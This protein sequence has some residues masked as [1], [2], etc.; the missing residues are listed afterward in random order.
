MK[1][2]RL[3]IAVAGATFALAACTNTAEPAAQP[4][5][6]VVGP[7]GEISLPEGFDRWPT[8][9][10][11]ATAAGGE[12]QPVDEM[13]TVY[14]SPGGIESY[15]VTGEF[16][17][18]T[19]LVKDV[20]EAK[21]TLLTTGDAHWPTDTKVWF[22]MVKDS[23]GKH[24]SRPLWAEGWGWALFGSDDPKKQIAESFENDCQACHQPTEA[25]E[26]IYAEAYPVLRKN[27][28]IGSPSWDSEG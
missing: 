3:A 24:E 12:G 20:R 1:L 22:V 27:G 7:Q 19:V 9:G 6:E 16:A 23:S 4:K 17:D 13:H 14:V 11:W 21:S 25:T 28:E 26:W 2:N 10:A 8:L 5:I 15:L 18:G